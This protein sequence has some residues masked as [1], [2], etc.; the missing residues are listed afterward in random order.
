MTLQFMP[1]DADATFPAQAVPDAVDFDILLLAHQ[2]TGV[3]SGL[4]VTESASPGMK[5]DIASGT[6]YL[7]WVEVSVSTQADKTIAAADGT[8]DRVDLVSINSGGTAVVTTGT[9]VSDPVAPPVPASSIP[10]AYVYV[11]ASDTS[12]VDN[13]IVIKR[14]IIAKAS[15]GGTTYA[16]V[17]DANF[18]TIS[19]GAFAW[20]FQEVVPYNN[21]QIHGIVM[22]G[23]VV[24]TATYQAAVMT[25]SGGTIAT[26]DKTG[27]VTADATDAETTWGRVMMLF[28][29]PVSLT[30]GTEYFIGSG[31]TDSS[32]TYAF[33]HLSRDNVQYSFPFG[34]IGSSGRARIAKANPAV[35]D[36]IVDWTTDGALGVG[37]F[38]SLD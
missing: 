13:Q 21:M 30:A 10:L 33:P 1:S 14:V 5:V 8:F 9:A 24:D 2:G 29:T 4:A 31:R 7:A 34:S 26:I 27:S 38:W 16:E 22:G 23:T 28:T 35:S 32:D 25:K 12:I 37:V 20:K 17:S 3:K 15:P 11:P 19:G 6:G 36:T 18:V